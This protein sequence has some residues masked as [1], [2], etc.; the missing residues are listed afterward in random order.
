M[1][2]RSSEKRLVKSEKE[3][4][5]ALPNSQVTNPLLIAAIWV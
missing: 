3:N 1:L 5:P 4:R 2:I